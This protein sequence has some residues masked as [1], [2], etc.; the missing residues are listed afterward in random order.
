MKKRIGDI[1]RVGNKNR[2]FGSCSHYFHFR[3]QLNGEEA[4]Y[5]FTEAELT[6]AK[7]RAEKNQEDLIN[8]STLRDLL[9]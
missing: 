2:R 5:L 6:A 3:G 9:D 1:N 8:P 7:E 4:H